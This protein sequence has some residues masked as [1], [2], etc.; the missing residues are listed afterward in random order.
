MFNKNLIDLNLSRSK[1]INLKNLLSYLIKNSS[2]AIEPNK[3]LF[4]SNNPKYQS[5]YFYLM[6]APSNWT[7]DKDLITEKDT[8]IQF[9]QLKEYHCKG[10]YSDWGKNVNLTT[11]LI[12]LYNYFKGFPMHTDY[13][14]NRPKYSLI[15]TIVKVTFGQYPTTIR[16][17]KGYSFI[18]TTY[19]NFQKTLCDNPQILENYH[20]T[21]FI[22]HKSTWEMIR[23]LFNVSD[24]RVCGGSH[25]KRHLISPLEVRLIDSM[26]RI[27]SFEL[28]RMEWKK[29]SY[30]DMEDLSRELLAFENGEIKL[31]EIQLE[32][33][34]Y[35]LGLDK[36]DD[37]DSSLNVDRILKEYRNALYAI[38]IN[39]YKNYDNKVT[40]NFRDVYNTYHQLFSIFNLHNPS[41]LVSDLRFLNFYLY[42]FT[43]DRFLFKLE[44]QYYSQFSEFILEIDKLLEN[45]PA[46]TTINSGVN[47]I[48]TRSLTSIGKNLGKRNYSSIVP[49]NTTNYYPELLKKIT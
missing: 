24:I 33:I 6:L 41:K 12:L 11:A 25:T 18:S 10:I 14:I 3:N 26:E 8:N 31:N 32:L 27:K 30:E 38:S 44:D 4:N 40:K 5:E 20:S 36:Y 34:K 2:L 28:D 43:P 9:Q 1:L 35:K 49:V 15:T 48:S 17:Y 46:I 47:R 21:L 23:I 19:D 45:K 37:N 42:D 22:F 13:F 7:L 29:C 39:S 16:N